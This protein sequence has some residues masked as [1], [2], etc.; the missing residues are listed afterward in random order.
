[1]KKIITAVLVL[2]LLAVLTTASSGQAGTAADPLITQSYA[3]GTY[4][5]SIV[6]AG[7]E[8]INNRIN[9]ILADV[10]DDSLFAGFDLKRSD[11]W[12]RLAAQV[13]S[14]VTLVT[15]SSF[16]LTFGK[17]SVSIASGEVIDIATGRPVSSGTSLR[18]L[19]R[20]FCT[21][22]TVATFTSVDGITFLVEGSYSRGDGVSVMYPDYN[23]VLGLE[24]YTDPAGFVKKTGL[25]H[26]S[27]S[28]SFRPQETI[29]RAELVYALWVAFGRQESD[30]EPMFQDLA[31]DWYTPAVRWAAEH[32]ITAGL[33]DT[34]FGPLGGVNREQ[35]ASMLYRTASVMG[36]DVS[37]RA[38]LSVYSDWETINDW[39][40]DPISWATA[41]GFLSGMGNGTVSPLLATTRA[42]A[43]SVIMR[44]TAVNPTP[45]G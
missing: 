45:V 43:A 5:D 23:D 25:Y 4:A 11:G 14:T 10:G 18:Q 20:Y 31:E 9:G 32:G 30:Y 42:Q 40:R 44:Y 16:M 27:G 8:I 22:D 36:I 35:F 17:A 34:V 13:G 24:W 29:T 28:A 37:E 38:N 7:A 3:D 41:E 39:G 26:D 6:D 1:M 15:G 2:S 33:S 21:E 19:S 12:E